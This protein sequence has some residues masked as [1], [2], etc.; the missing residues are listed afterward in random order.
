MEEFEA[1]SAFAAV[2][3][4]LN[5]LRNL[6]LVSPDLQIIQNGIAGE[7]AFVS[8]GITIDGNHNLWVGNL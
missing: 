8:W 4:N 2:N 5:T 6:A 1:R 7:V 3:P